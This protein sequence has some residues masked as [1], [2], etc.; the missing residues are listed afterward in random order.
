MKLSDP[1]PTLP[2]A[3]LNLA[4]SRM[5]IEVMTKTIYRWKKTM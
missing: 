4:D 5:C 3:F 2:T 1:S